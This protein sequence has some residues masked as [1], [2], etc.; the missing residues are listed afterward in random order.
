MTEPRTS[1]SAVRAAWPDVVR[2]TLRA[3]LSD[4]LPLSAAG[5]AFC[6][7]L[8]LFPAMGTLISLY[9]LVSNPRAAETQVLFLR[10]LLPPN[11]YWLIADRLHHL[12][13]QPPTRLGAGLA[14]SLLLTVWSAA[15][16]VRAMLA[17][18]ALA[19]DEPPRRGFLRA[20]AIALAI[21][22]L[23]IL[24]ATV[25]LSVLVV[26][27]AMFHFV[28]PWAFRMRVVHAA[29]L[30][31]LLV[32]AAASIAV[33]YRFA[34]GRRGVTLLPGLLLAISV[35]LA[36]SLLL[37][38]YV[39]HIAPFGVAYGPIGAVVAVML[40]FF[41]TAYAVLLGAELNAQL[42]RTAGRLALARETPVA[43]DDAGGAQ[44]T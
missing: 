30:A 43:A 23:A 34:A 12:V 5:C 13:V 36:A 39:D 6:A 18:L 25:T 37:S 22:L 4:R 38:L 9:G 1:R 8:A 26:L 20:Q 14:I 17:A 19:F 10:A 16:G 2:A 28:W 41:L 40:W 24:G 32:C 35:W 3:S 15:F 42:E 31:V 44:L 21:A 7:T 29:S 11:A 33:L 27:P